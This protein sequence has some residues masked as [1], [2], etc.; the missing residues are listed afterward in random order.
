MVNLE[1]AFTA[2]LAQP[3]PAHLQPAA[4]SI[5]ADAGIAPS[6]RPS[7]TR[8]LAIRLT[9]RAI[10]IPAVASVISWASWLT[11]PTATYITALSNHVISKWPLSA[12]LECLW[13][14]FTH[15][16]PIEVMPFGISYLPDHTGTCL[17][18]L[19]NLLQAVRKVLS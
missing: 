14:V 6:T 7:P 12:C 16:N 4:I 10:Q 15:S 11:R 9:E 2:T 18:A 19:W 1:A 5:S 3:H 17:A 13:E 8:C